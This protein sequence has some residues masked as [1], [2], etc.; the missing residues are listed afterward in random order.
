MPNS[1]IEPD[2]DYID[3]L[4]ERIISGVFA[5]SGTTPHP[6]NVGVAITLNSELVWLKTYVGPT[7]NESMPKNLFEE[8]AESRARLAYD[9]QTDT[10]EI[11]PALMGG[12]YISPYRG[13][14]L[15]IGVASFADNDA[16]QTIACM[17]MHYL[18]LTAQ[19]YIKEIDRE[20]ELLTVA[21]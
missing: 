18:V 5:L 3:A 2:N 7:W 15:A 10:A 9:H 8:E 21:V 4:F 6:Y 17:I 14:E 1:N 19:M 12:I 13:A 11:C 20:Q 16:K